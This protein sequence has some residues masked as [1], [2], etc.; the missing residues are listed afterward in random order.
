MES[1]TTPFGRRPMTLGML[2]SQVRGREIAPDRTADK[3]KLFRALCEA[4]PRLGITDRALALLNALLSFYPKAELAAGDGL[5]VFPSNAQLSLRAN[6]MAE[7]TIRRHLA[8]LVEAGLILRKDSANGKRYARRD[9]EGA[10]DEA[11]GFSLAPLLARADE[12][13]RLA[14]DVVAERLAFQRLRERLTIARRDVSKLIEAALE[15]GAPGDWTMALEEHRTILAGLGRKPSASDVMAALD[16]MEALREEI[17]NQLETI[18]LSQ[19]P[20]GNPL[21]DERHIQNSNTEST[22]ESEQLFEKEQG[23]RPGPERKGLAVPPKTFPL[24]LVLSA[25]PDIADYGPEG[26]VK[27]WRDLMAAAV[28]VRTMLGVSPSAYQEA[29]EVMGPENAAIAMACILERANEIQ[30]AGGYLRDLSRRAA[31]GEFSVGPMLMAALRGR[32]GGIRQAS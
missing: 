27:S 18:A 2:A 21:Q 9:G 15:E 26:A 30:S 19:I 8:A 24:G 20:S 3:W 4:R 23:E 10:L 32:G 11:F 5:V 31:R 13:E 16:A 1:V 12:I 29:C 22:H 7:A 14:A 25:C 6:G 28:V 17:V